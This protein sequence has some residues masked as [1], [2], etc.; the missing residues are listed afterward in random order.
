MKNIKNS[1]P[2]TKSTGSYKKK[3]CSQV[4]NQEI[5]IFVT[6]ALSHYWVSDMYGFVNEP[7]LEKGIFFF[8]IISSSGMS[9][10]KQGYSK[11]TLCMRFNFGLENG[12]FKKMF[13]PRGETFF[14]S[15][16]LEFFCQKVVQ[17]NCW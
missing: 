6:V 8:D 17:K 15:S 12:N 9:K 2:Q 1:Q 14:K 13:Y 5:I 4:I 16:C 11:K 7:I 10:S 3:E